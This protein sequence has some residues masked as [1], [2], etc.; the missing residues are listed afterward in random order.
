MAHLCD[1]PCRAAGGVSEH[2]QGPRG[3]TL[4][5]WEVDFHAGGAARLGVRSPDGREVRVDGVCLEVAEPERVVFTGHVDVGGE[6][7][8]EMPGRVTFRRA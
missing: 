4:L 6:R 3:Y 2:W 1:S 8:D 7:L 5:S